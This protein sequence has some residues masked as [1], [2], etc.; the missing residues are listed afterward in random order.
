M[1]GFHH[2]TLMPGVFHAANLSRFDGSPRVIA[3]GFQVCDGKLS[4]RRDFF[5]VER[6]QTRVKKE[7]PSTRVSFFRPAARIN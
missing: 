5:C 6:E 7:T 2:G 4:A 3:A 1:C